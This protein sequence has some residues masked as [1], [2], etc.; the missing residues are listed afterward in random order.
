MEKELDEVSEGKET[1][2]KTCKDFYTPFSK[3]LEQKYKE[4][5]K[6]NMVKETDKICP[7]CNSPLLERMGRFGKFYACSK[8]PECK[9]TESIKDE[10][11]NTGI[12]CPKCAQ[13][14]LI[15]KKTK[16][17]KIFYGCKNFPNCDMATWDKPVNEFCPKCNSILIQPKKGQIKCANKDCHYKK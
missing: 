4:V 17:G 8:F 5:K 3:N 16:R 12:T 7:K 6:S 11:K 9:Y 13:G 1:W 15:E 14:E 10:S 2:Q